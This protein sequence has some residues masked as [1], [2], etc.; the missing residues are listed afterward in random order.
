MPVAEPDRRPWPETTVA[1]LR[2][3]LRDN[4]DPW[5][6]FEHGTCVVVTDH[7]EDADLQQ[8]AVQVLQRFGPVHA[9]SPA[10]DFDIV[11][12]TRVRA[13]AITSHHP[14]VL[15]FVDPRELQWT[16]E[17]EVGLHGRSKRDRDGRELRVVHVESGARASGR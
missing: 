9:G 6:L 7:V 13:Y 14:N 10:G 11:S 12:L 15:T 3:A 1:G 5:V 2:L 4:G 8:R 17:V 16:D